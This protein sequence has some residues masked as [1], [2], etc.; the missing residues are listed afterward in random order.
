MFY[1]LWK[2]FQNVRIESASAPIEH[3]LDESDL[4]TRMRDWIVFI[5]GHIKYDSVMWQYQ[6]WKNVLWLHIARLRI[7]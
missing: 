4:L 5:A 1:F 6:E 2:Y 3:M 7:R